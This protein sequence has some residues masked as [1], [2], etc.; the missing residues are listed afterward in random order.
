MK[1][2]PPL[3]ESA[4]YRKCDPQLIPFADTGEI[5]VSNVIFGQRRALDAI[6]LLTGRTAGDVE[7]P[8]KKGSENLNYLVARR[9]EEFSLLRRQFKG[10]KGKKGRKRR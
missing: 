8:G 5:A 10:T 2:H 9:L 7:N 1:K 4:L 6:E 3:N